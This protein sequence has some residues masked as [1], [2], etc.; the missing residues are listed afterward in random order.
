MLT[1]VSLMVIPSL[2]PKAKMLVAV[3]GASA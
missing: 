3:V 2:P 1:G